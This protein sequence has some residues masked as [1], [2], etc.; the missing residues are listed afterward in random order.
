MG[1]SRFSYAVLLPLLLLSGSYAFPSV[2]AQGSLGG[3][4]RTWH[5][6]VGGESEN[7]A[8][9]AEAF[10]PGIITIDAGDTVVW[11][12][13]SHEPHSVT[14]LGSGEIPPE[15]AAA[16]DFAPC[17][18]PFPSPYDGIGFVGSGFMKPPGFNWDNSFPLPHG[19]T[20]FALTFANPG[21]YVYQ[22][23]I[24]AGMQGVVVV[25]PAGTPHPF[26]QDDYS[27]QA[28]KQLRADLVTGVHALAMFKP[29]KD[30]SNPDG[31]KTHFAATGISGPE[32]ADVPLSSAN[33]GGPTGK[34]SLDLSVTSQASTLTVK[35]SL[36]GLQPGSVHSARIDYGVCGTVAKVSPFLLQSFTLNAITARSDGKGESN[37]I[38]STPASRNGIQNIRIQSAGWFVAVGETGETSSDTLACGNVVFRSVSVER[39]LPSKLIVNVGDTVVWEQLDLLH[40]HFV[41]FPAGQPLPPFPTIVFQPPTGNAT[42]YNG[43]SFFISDNLLA[44][45]SLVLTL[46]QPGTLRYVEPIEAS[47]EMQG[48]VIVRS[49]TDE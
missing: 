43:R 47:L 45:Q 14:F 31:T 20:T 24:Q 8:I 49:N 5:I 34:A 9:Q 25:Q 4:P 26:S 7:K 33:T 39:L 46:T 48:T 16:S 37:T 30:V 36:A 3:S 6:L 11:T 17:P 29:P 23:V 10:F 18:T 19:N 35:I 2:H 12:L 13:N 32:A 27:K 44:G 38:I 42:S 1:I 15:C 21:A 28:A 22:S 40:S 41:A